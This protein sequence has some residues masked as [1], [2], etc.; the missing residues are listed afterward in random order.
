MARRTFKTG[1]TTKFGLRRERPVD[2]SHWKE[3]GLEAGGAREKKIL[4]H[5]KSKHLFLVKFPKYGS[6]EIVTEVFNSI[7]AAELGINHVQYFPISYNGKAGVACQSFIDPAA[8]EKGLE[9]LWEM[10]E[11]VC[12]YSRLVSTEKRFG[13]DAEVLKEHNLDYIN[14]ILETEFGKTVMPFFFEMIGID[15]L[16]G[17]GDRH[18]SN[19][20]VIVSTKNNQI[21]AK[22]APLYDTA[23]GYLTEYSD[24]PEASEAELLKN[25]LQ[26]D[27]RNEDWY[28]V[29]KKGLCKITLPD[30]IKANHFD[31][32]ARVIAMDSMKRYKDSAA[33]AFRNFDAKLPR[34]ILSR[35]FKDLDPLRVQVIETILV[36]RHRIGCSVFSI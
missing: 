31:L 8:A 26:T 19:Y 1:F 33:K 13:R 3:V 5:P 9:E 20:G 24:T 10:K 4:Q 18:W 17:H 35:Y 21:Q 23:S 6:F 34:A 28:K 29:K 22:Y 12:R 15:A 11:L 36:K 16:I 30:D 25:A 27:L 32:L 7:L 14:L 2:I